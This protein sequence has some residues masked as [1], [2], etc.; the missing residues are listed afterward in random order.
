MS[1]KFKYKY[2]PKRLDL[3]PAE[4]EMA[5]AAT[6][7]MRDL[8]KVLQSQVRA[9]MARGGLTKRFFN[10]FRVRV[11]PKAGISLTP[12]LRGIHP[13]GFIN[14]FERGGTSMGKPL[15]WLPLP[16]APLKIGGKRTTVKRYIELVGPLR[17]INV[18]GEPPMLAGETL[19]GVAP[20]ARATVASLKTGARNAAARRS[21]GKGRRTVMVPLFVGVKATHLA[22][23]LRVGPIYEKARDQLPALY[24]ARMANEVR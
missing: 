20:G 24:A 10:K 14:V 3:S 11:K 17:S 21:G 23:R 7:A 19:R 18:P 13:Y 2:D 16:S 1:A 15:L 12:S 4:R 22:A 6:G 5:R 8:A 9:E